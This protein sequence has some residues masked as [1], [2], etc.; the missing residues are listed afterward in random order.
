MQANSSYESSLASRL[1]FPGPP[2]SSLT[3]QVS[4]IFQDQLEASLD[5]LYQSLLMPKILIAPVADI[6]QL[7]I[8]LSVVI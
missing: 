7:T 4:P 3:F 1:L 5:I 6:Q 2:M 8:T